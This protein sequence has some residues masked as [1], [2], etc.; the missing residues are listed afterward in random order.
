[1]TETTDGGNPYIFSELRDVIFTGEDRAAAIIG[2]DT[3]LPKDKAREK[4]SDEYGLPPEKIF[5]DGET[6]GSKAS[7]LAVGFSKWR[8]NWDPHSKTADPNM[9]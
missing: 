7:R 5:L 9:N 4:L 8:S 1:M 3:N 2:Y 6:G